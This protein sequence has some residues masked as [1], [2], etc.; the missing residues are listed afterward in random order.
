M[1]DSM[2]VW[3]CVCLRSALAQACPAYEGLI[4]AGLQC[5][6]VDFSPWP[7]TQKPHCVCDGVCGCP[8]LG[9]ALCISLYQPLNTHTQHTHLTQPTLPLT[10]TT[11][12]LTCTHTLL[13]ALTSPLLGVCTVHWVLGALIAH[14]KLR[15]ALFPRPRGPFFYPQAFLLP[16]AQRQA[17]SSGSG[18]T[19]N[20]LYG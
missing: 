8:Q 4:S 10:K 19:D 16:Y 9:P 1:N 6:P 5:L 14:R 12:S 2:C 3:L 15:G 7:G 18:V 17:P 13:H 20:V 11:H